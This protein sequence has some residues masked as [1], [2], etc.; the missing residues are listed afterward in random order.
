MVIS[1]TKKEKESLLSYLEGYLPDAYAMAEDFPEEE[2]A[3][4]E[5]LET[6]KSI[7]SKLRKG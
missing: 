6:V 1:L 7:I 3:N 2:E 5:W 4:K